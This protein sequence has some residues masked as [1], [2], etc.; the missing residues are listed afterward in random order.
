MTTIRPIAPVLRKT[1][2]ETT[3]SVERSCRIL[4]ALSDPSVDRL[5]AIALATALDKATVSRVLEVLVRDGFV[6]RDALTKRYTLGAELLVLGSAALK[7]FDPKPVARPSLLRLA[8]SFE[9]TVILSLPSGVES[10]C[11]DVLEGR[12]PIKANYLTVGSRRPLGVGAGSLALLAWMPQEER[13]AAL[14]VI[15]PQLQ[16]YPRLDAELLERHARKARDQ[17]YVVM[18]DAVVERMGGI[19]APVLGPDGRPV[20]A[21]SIAALSDRIVSREAELAKA[22]RRECRVCEVRW[23]SARGDGARKRRR[24]M[25]SNAQLAPSLAMNRLRP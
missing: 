21:I 11:V 4:R 9:D 25:H 22:L 15:G 20:A 23:S 3:S 13:Q 18:L 14:A 6:E 5:T 17:G 8:G 24:S 16:R 10:L 19:A 2:S 1:M 12:F 7:C